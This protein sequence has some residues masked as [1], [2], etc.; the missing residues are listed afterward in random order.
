MSASDLTLVLDSMAPR[1]VANGAKDLGVLF[2]DLS[3]ASPALLVSV[4]EARLAMP[5]Y[6]GFLKPPESKFR[7]GSVEA[8]AETL[9]SRAP[10]FQRRDEQRQTP[11]QPT[12]APAPTTQTVPLNAA[13]NAANPLVAHLQRQVKFQGGGGRLLGRK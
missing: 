6:A 9:K 4:I 12:P 2:G 1:L 7:P 13:L 11:V 3:E 8:Y 10:G 5:Q